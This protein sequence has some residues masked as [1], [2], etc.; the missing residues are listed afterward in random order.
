VRLVQVDHLLD[1]AVVPGLV[2]DL[3]ERDLVEEV[4][5]EVVLDAV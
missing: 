4:E 5:A 1:G 3:D 2:G